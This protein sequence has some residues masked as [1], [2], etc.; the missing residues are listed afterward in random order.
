MKDALGDIYLEQVL[1]EFSAGSV[2]YVNGRKV[3]VSGKGDHE[4][5]WI[6]YELGPEGKD[7]DRK[8]D[9]RTGDVSNDSSER[10]NPTNEEAEI[11]GGSASGALSTSGAHKDVRINERGG[12][13]RP[14][15]YDVRKK[16]RAKVF[17]KKKPEVSPKT[18]AQDTPSPMPD[19]SPKPRSG[20]KRVLSVRDKRKLRRAK[21]FS[22]KKGPSI[23]DFFKGPPKESDKPSLADFFKDPL[24][25]VDAKP[26]LADAQ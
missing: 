18:H 13:A 4:D 22:D 26:S 17:G 8:V 5:T 19:I 6:G 3:R 16:R 7:S 1:L 10:S 21:T 15:A 12:A 23:A 25:P 24:P 11:G 14:S 20:P 2:V 9:F